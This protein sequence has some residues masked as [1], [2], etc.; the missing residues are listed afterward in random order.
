[1][2]TRLS[3]IALLLIMMMFFAMLALDIAVPAM[4]LSAMALSKWLI[5]MDIPVPERKGETA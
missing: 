1:M 5:S 3:R 4:V 2:G